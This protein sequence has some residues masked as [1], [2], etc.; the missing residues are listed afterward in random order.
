MEAT[1]TPLVVENST[2]EV[3]NG[4][5]PSDGVSNT[6]ATTEDAN[7][8]AATDDPETVRNGVPTGKVGRKPVRMTL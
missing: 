2:G 3:P 5:T 4:E 8:A 7:E 1:P 6:E